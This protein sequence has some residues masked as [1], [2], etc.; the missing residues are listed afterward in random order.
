MEAARREAWQQMEQMRAHMAQG[1]AAWQ[2]R[3]AKLEADA[4]ATVK[5]HKKRWALALVLWVVFFL[6]LAA[7]VYLAVTAR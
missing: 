1:D 7:D 6:V 3:V 2:A 5:R 4:A